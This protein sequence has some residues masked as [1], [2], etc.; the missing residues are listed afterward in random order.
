MSLTDQ[1]GEYFGVERGNG[2]LISSVEANSPAARAGL[3]AGDVLLTV[4]GAD[5]DGITALRRALGQAE[6][7]IRLYIM[8]DRARQELQVT[9]ESRE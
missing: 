1:L 9:L 2:V 7:T 3:R 5:V 8:R 6:G 4:D